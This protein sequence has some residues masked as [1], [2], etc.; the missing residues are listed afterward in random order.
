MKWDAFWHLF[1][2]LLDGKEGHGL[3]PAVIDELCQ[4]AFGETFA[5]KI[6]H[7]ECPLS[8]TTDGK[9][10]FADLL[11]AYTSGSGDATHVII[12]DDIDSRSSGSNRKIANLI[13]YQRLARLSYPYAIVRAV[14]MTNAQ[15]GDA[16]HKAKTALGQ[17]AADHIVKDGWKLLPISTVGSWV[18]TAINTSVLSDQKMR[19]FLADFVEWSRSLNS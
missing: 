2:W 8:G 15:N 6:I 9:G 12:M 16:M 4:Y 7:S 5:V 18:K 19:L 17:E 11:V 1:T 13:E 14:V 10:K 3:G